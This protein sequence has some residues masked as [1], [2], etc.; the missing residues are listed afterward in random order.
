M[1]KKAG[2]LVVMLLNMQLSFSQ[3]VDDFS[4][5]DFT[6]NPAWSGDNG[7]FT[8]S[9]NQLNSQSGAAGNYYLSTPS[10]LALNT[11]WDF[12]FNMKFG[13]SGA[14]Y[15][16]VYLISDVA[17][18]T[19]P[20]DGYFVRIGGTPDEVSLYKI[21]SG[22]P[23][24][25][26][27]GPDG[28]V[29]ST[30]NNPFDVRVTRDVANNWTLL[31]DDGAS[32]NLVAIGSI[33]DNSVVASNFFGISITQSGAAGPINNHYFDNFSVASIVGDTSAPQVDSLTVLGSSSLDVHF[34]E[35]VDLI[36]SQ[37]LNNYSVA[38]LGGP[39]AVTRDLLDSTVV[40]LTFSTTFTNGQNYNLTI[41]DVQDTAGNSITTV[42]EP[43]RYLVFISPRL[44]D[45]IINEIFA[46][47]SPTIGL[48][49]EEYLELFNKTTKVIDL[50]DCWIADLTS[51]SQ[52]SAGKIFP[53][54]YVIVCDN[55]FESQ[56]SLLG[57][58]ITVS[59]FPSLNNSADEVTLYSSDTSL[60]HQ[61]HY[62]DSWYK[63]DTKKHGGW[64]LEMIDPNNPCGEGG[65]W[66]ASTGLHGGTPGKQNTVYGANPDVIL[67]MLTE[68]IAIDDSTVVVAFSEKLSNAGALTA[69]FTIDYGVTIGSFEMLDAKNV[70]LNLSN[71]LS[72]RIKYEV[73]V[74][75]AYDCV[76][77]VIG[78]DNTAVFG[79][80]EDSGYEDLI[81]NEILFNPFIGGSDFVE[82]Y[83]NSDKFINLENWNLANLEDDSI[84]NS[85]AV[86]VKPK[87]IFPGDFVVLTKDGE[88]IKNDYSGTVSASILQMESFPNY[89][90]DKGSVYL[91]NDLNTVVDSFHYKEEM[92]FALLN[93][94]DGVSLERID[95]KRTALDKTNWHSAAEDVG[96]A[97][98]G[99]EN[100][101]YQKAI[102]EESE[103][104][105]SPLTFSPNNDGVDDVV[106]ISYNFLDPGFV[107]NIVIYDTKGR[108]VKNF[109]QNE[110]LGTSG[111][112]SWDG[113][114]EQN[115][116][117]GIGIYIIF[118]EAFDEEGNVKLFKKTVVLAERLG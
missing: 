38:G 34:N 64:S 19:T 62:D 4:D 88:A 51:M 42:I 60:I 50:T 108:L 105:I 68:A 89:S 84:A 77:N 56:F 1:L 81:I 27:D 97:T 82:I 106:N 40:H 71:K 112:F 75:D 21:V 104:I 103:I 87:L 101:Q 111:T 72:F 65:N 18:V 80:P 25:L 33:V 6:S 99:Y 39:S 2:F 29:N 102:A 5:G 58:V 116:K 48:P 10:T 94:Y 57:K 24:I 52:L 59:N 90:N 43:F 47:P 28:S 12:Y 45:L 69:T 15:V 46:D 9:T 107:A 98:P 83:N 36:T 91:M 3:F 63:D 76:G 35:P 86:S 37:V 95:Y 30:S 16:D 93:D 14:N 74:S 17:D 85:K 115:E 70:Q 66:T 118:V 54:E 96:F 31:Y 8:V 44:G 100:S 78:S 55:S 53:G 20:N 23:T 114:T 41:V 49:T 32:T 7:L 61:I 22:I 67:P 26:I 92:H 109:L 79:L 113:I 117:A 11:Q 13:T 73:M 110:L